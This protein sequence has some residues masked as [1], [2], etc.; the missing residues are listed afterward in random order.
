MLALTIA[1]LGCT[2]QP[3]GDTR[4]AA[5]A[6]AAATAAAAI[7]EVDALAARALDE[8]QIPAWPSWCCAMTNCCSHAATAWR[9]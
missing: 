5:A 3:A 7:S 8:H 6:E 4:A 1:M 2:N 9:I